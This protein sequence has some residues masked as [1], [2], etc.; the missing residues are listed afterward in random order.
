MHYRRFGLVLGVLLIVAST[1]M[2]TGCGAKRQLVSIRVTPDNLT[3]TGEGLIVNYRAIGSYINP[4]ETR[5]ITS[6]V[7]WAST[8]PQIIS[9]DP[10]TGVAV[11]GFGCGTNIGITATHYYNQAAKTGAAIVGTAG[12]NVVQPAGVCQ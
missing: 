1:A 12:M 11:S 10:N 8:A 6:Q 2:V 5:D 3:I 7:A 9:I 4:V